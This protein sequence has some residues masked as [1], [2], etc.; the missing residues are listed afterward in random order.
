LSGEDWPLQKNGDGKKAAP[1]QT[2]KQNQAGENEF[3]LGQCL[4]KQH[5]MRI[6]ENRKQPLRERERR[7]SGCNRRAESGKA[8]LP[9]TEARGFLCD[10]LRARKSRSHYGN[11]N[12]SRR[13]TNERQLRHFP[14][15]KHGRLLGP[16]QDV[17]G[18]QRTEHEKEADFGVDLLWPR[19]PSDKEKQGTTKNNEA[20]IESRG[21]EQNQA[22]KWDLASALASDGMVLK[23]SSEE[24]EVARPRPDMKTKSNTLYLGAVYHKHKGKWI[25]HTR[26]KNDFSSAIQT[27][28]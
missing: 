3:G 15:Q 19:T 7:K 26:S 14:W 28:L 27:G 10:D 2:G 1:W 20:K 25:T 8:N 22:G 6:H 21:G 17:E 16:N 18:E 12:Q 11:W 4:G 5:G 9:W 24:N 13:K 23:P